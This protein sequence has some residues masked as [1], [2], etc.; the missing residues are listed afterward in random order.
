MKVFYDGSCPICSREIRTYQNRDK[1]NRLIP[2][3]ITDPSFVAGEY[4]L[5]PEAVNKELHACTADGKVYT[6]VD[7][8]RKI[9]QAV[10]MQPLATL[11]RLPGLSQSMDLG[12]KLFS[13]YRHQLTGQC[14]RHTCSR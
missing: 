11:T 6:A 9:W 5:D 4:G 13:R 12:Y 8:F 10:G 1:Y 7:A 3:D 2:I 14:N